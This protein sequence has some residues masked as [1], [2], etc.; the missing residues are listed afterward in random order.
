M[1]YFDVML[2]VYLGVTL[3]TD[4]LNALDGHRQC[5]TIPDAA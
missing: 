4:Q 2:T 1:T 5:V 3:E